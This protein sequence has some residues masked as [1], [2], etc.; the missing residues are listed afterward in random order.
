MQGSPKKYKKRVSYFQLCNGLF[1]LVLILVMIIPLINVWAVSFSSGIS[2]MEPGVKLWPADFS[3]SGYQR[4]W[5]TLELW[6][7]FFNNVLVT[8][9]GTAAHVLLA[10]MAGYVLIHPRLVGRKIIVS[11]IMITMMVPAEAIMIPLYIVNKELG[12]LDT[13][14]SL[15]I[16]GLISGFSILLMRNYFLSV[17]YSLAESAQMDGASDFKIFRKV[18]TPMSVPGLATIMLFEF[19]SRWNQFTPA[20]LYINSPEKYTLQLALMSLIVP[21]DA[22]SSGDFFANNVQMAGIMI[23]MIPL[24]VIYPFVQKYFIR[25]INLGA[26]KE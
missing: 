7:P 16:S 17:P 1:L 21:D 11:M 9:I 18:Y 25:G 8:V 14:A 26:T 12:L 22:T 19:V 24:L 4:V 20:L 6:R 10:S 23:A 2:S 5:Q 13:L 3:V 15:V